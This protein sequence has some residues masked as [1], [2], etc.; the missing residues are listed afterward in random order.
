[1]TE[2]NLYLFRGAVLFIH[3]LY[4]AAFFGVVLIDERYVRNFSTVVQLGVCVFLIYR[5]FPYYR[6]TYA[7][8][9]LDVSV[10][11]FCA[12]FMLLNVVSVEVYSAFFKGTLLDRIVSRLPNAD[13]MQN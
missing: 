9:A 7:L 5:F 2:T 12:T 13:T 4:L 11:F 1:M 6:T 10:I 8:T 3:L